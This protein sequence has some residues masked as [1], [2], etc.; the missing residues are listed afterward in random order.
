MYTKYM[1]V[2]TSPMCKTMTANETCHS[3]QE[4]TLS[5]NSVNTI[6]KSRVSRQRHSS[7]ATQECTIH[8]PYPVGRD[9]YNTVAS[10]ATVILDSY[11]MIVAMIFYH[12]VTC[13]QHGHVHGVNTSPT[14][15][16]SRSRM[17][18]PVPGSR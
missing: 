15:T 11:R 6:T 4:L 16:R 12:V 7:F 10:Y 1:C 13:L 5:I 9:M 17:S 18:P 2:Y 14:L 8:S 3:C